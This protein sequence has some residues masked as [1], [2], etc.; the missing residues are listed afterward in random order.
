MK[1]L[2]A[3]AVFVLFAIAALFAVTANAQL[4]ITGEGNFTNGTWNPSQPD[5]FQTSMMDNCYS[6]EVTNLSSFKISTSCGSWDEFNAGVLG[7]NYGDKTGVA[8]QLQPG[9]D[10]NITCPWAGDYTIKVAADLSTI[11]LTT[12]TP[13]PG[14]IPVYLR[15]D[16]NSWGAP[17]EWK[18][19]DLGDGVY[20]FVCAEG[21][22][23]TTNQAFK[24]ADANWAKV[25]YGGSGAITMGTDFLLTYNSSSNLKVAETFNGVCWFVLNLNGSGKSYVTLS[26]DKSFVP[27]WYGAE[28]KPALYITGNGDFTN[29]QWNPENP[30]QFLFSNGAYRLD[31]NNLVSFKLSTTKGSWDEFNTGVLG[32]QYGEEPGLAVDLQAGWDGDISCPWKGNYTIV[33]SEDFSTITLTTDTPKPGDDPNPALDIYLRGG[34]N[35]WEAPA[36]WKFE[37]LG[38]GVYKFVCAEGQ[39][40]TTSHEFKIADATWSDVNYG[41]VNSISL[42]A[43]YTLI[44]NSGNMKVAED[45]NGVCWLGINYNNSGETQLTMSNDKTFVPAWYTPV[46]V[47]DVTA[48]KGET[49]YF[50]LQGQKVANPSNGIFV[51]V[52]NG[53]AVKVAVK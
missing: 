25:N 28:E 27:E 45:F 53:K 2:Y 1:K 4:Y 23:I 11:T 52:K 9:Y 49:I 33:V 3:F 47:E 34:M 14:A 21:Q 50:N 17:D 16:M 15:G 35:N 12:T 39:S 8:V 20:K 38:D 40:I 44:Y 46:M 6:I 32:C 43:D 31:V 26:N 48:D 22:S 29:G 37:S 42:D 5:E 24:V 36:D 7:C 51:A 19:E 10:A 13:N 30:D 41:G 18:F